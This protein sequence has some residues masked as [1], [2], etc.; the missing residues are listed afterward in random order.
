M[1]LKGK[2]ADD[3]FDSLEGNFIGS[4]IEA[5][6][7]GDCVHEVESCVVAEL[8]EDA[9][10]GAV[11]AFVSFLKVGEFC[12][13]GRVEARSVSKEESVLKGMVDVLTWSWWPK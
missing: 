5:G 6:E 2:V 8:E 10:E 4:C 7:S 11:G 13:S 12:W 1:G 3:S 9:N